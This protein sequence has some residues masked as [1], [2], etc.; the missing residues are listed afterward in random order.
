MAEMHPTAKRLYVAAAMLDPPIR[1]QSAVA[2][3]LG[4]SPQAVNNWESRGVSGRGANRAQ[5][6]LGISATWIVHGEKPELIARSSSDVAGPATG[7]D[8]VRAVDMGTEGDMGEGR[9]N[10]D[11]PEVIRA[12]DYTQ[13]YIRGLVGFVPPPGRLVLVT[14]RGDSMLPTI[15]PGES[16]LVDTGVKTYDG[17]GIYLVNLG[18]GQQIKRLVDHGEAAGIHVHSDNKAY[19][20]LPFPKGGLVAGKVY[21]RNRVD[22]FN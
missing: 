13:K 7:P 17:D 14:G 19:P 20:T 8:Y 9:V 11:F 1:G 3:A 15:Q 10:D 6:K 12:V 22:R 4:E 16:L 21:L 18:N 2:H 5:S